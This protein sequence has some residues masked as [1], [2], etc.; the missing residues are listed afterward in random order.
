MAGTYCACSAACQTLVTRVVHRRRYRLQDN[1]LPDNDTV[2]A[3]QR[4]SSEENDPELRA[5]LFGNIV[6]ATHVGA[7]LALL[8]FT[9]VGAPWVAPC[10]CLCKCTILTGVLT[11]YE[12]LH[13]LGVL[14]TCALCRHAFLL[15]QKKNVAD[16]RG[17]PIAVR[18]DG[19]PRR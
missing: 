15:Q 6:L 7:L 14:T 1:A 10:S 11:P 13:Q 18:F 8:L 12:S 3:L 4:A 19:G 2:A 16:T 5:D 9:F 17:G